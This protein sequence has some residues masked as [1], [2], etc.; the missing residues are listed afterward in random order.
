MAD[1]YN[2]KR[3]YFLQIVDT[4]HIKENRVKFMSQQLEFKN[5]DLVII[6]AT[7]G[8]PINTINPELF[9]YNNTV[10]QD[11]ELVRQPDYKNGVVRLDYDKEISI[12]AQ[13]NRIMFAEAIGDKKPESLS[14]PSIASNYPQSLPNMEF[15]GLGISFRGYV[16]FTDSQD[17]R[18]YMSKNLFA[19]GAWQEVGDAPVRATVNLVYSFER[20]PLYLSINEASLRNSDETT[21]PIIMFS[22]SFSYSLS[23]ETAVEK[24]A[25]LQQAIGNWQTDLMTFSDIINNKFLAQVVENYSV[26]PNVFAMSTAV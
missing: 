23:G 10:P 14:V 17:A 18:Q 12:I 3:Y 5:Q 8:N 9:K 6:L 13:T 21:T 7:K 26:V 11:L 4:F 16:P 2:K 20:A 22:G 1:D 25:S 24:L 15:E 19:P